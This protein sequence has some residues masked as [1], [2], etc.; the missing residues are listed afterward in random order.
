MASAVSNFV[1]SL[2]TADCCLLLGYYM[3]PNDSHTGLSDQI[4]ELD[5]LAWTSQRAEPRVTV[6]DANHPTSS[7]AS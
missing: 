1:P 3:P 6:S 5:K 2:V 4:R 7:A